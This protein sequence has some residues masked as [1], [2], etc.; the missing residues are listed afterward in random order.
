MNRGAWQATAHW[1]TESDKTKRLTTKTDVGCKEAWSVCVCV[2]VCVCVQSLQ[3]KGR[4]S[5]KPREQSLADEQSHVCLVVSGVQVC[6]V[7]SD[8]ATPWIAA[9]KVPLAMAFSRQEY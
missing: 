5:K 6:S 9:H 2:C 4:T 8:S 3:R 1:V 7:G